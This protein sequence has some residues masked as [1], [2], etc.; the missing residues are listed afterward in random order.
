MD[1]DYKT[2]VKNNIQFYSEMIKSYSDKVI[3]D[4]ENKV[5]LSYEKKKLGFEMLLAISKRELVDSR[6]KLTWLV[7][8]LSA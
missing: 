1:Y 6:A 4:L 3:P 8:N 5:K 2:S 7:K